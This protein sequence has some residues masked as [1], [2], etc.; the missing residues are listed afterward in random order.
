MINHR[1]ACVTVRA[2]DH[3]IKSGNLPIIFI[4]HINYGFVF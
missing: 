4:E 2:S 1:A 3:T